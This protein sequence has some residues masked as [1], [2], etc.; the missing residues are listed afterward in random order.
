M[1][2]V[3]EGLVY[4]SDA[5]VKAVQEK[6]G[7]MTVIGIDIGTTSICVLSVDCVSGKILKKSVAERTAFMRRMRN[8][9]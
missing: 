3:S 2:A 8:G 5:Y 7:K 6:D 9:S 1:R 4:V